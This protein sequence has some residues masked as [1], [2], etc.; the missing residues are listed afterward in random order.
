MVD[1]KTSLKD[2]ATYLGM[3]QT[4]VSRGLSGYPEVAEAT[5]AKIRDAASELNYA[6]SSSAK[7]LS[8]GKALTIGHIIPLSEHMTLN[9]FYADFIAGAGETYAQSG[10]DM[11]ISMVGSDQELQAYREL[12]NSQKVDGFVLSE[13]VS[14]DPRI[15]LLQKLNVPF[16]LHGRS[17]D[18][19]NVHG[20][21]NWL[22]VNNQQGFELATRYLLELGHRDIG[23][24]NGLETF[25]FAHRRRLGFEA[26]MTAF[27]AP[28]HDNWLFNID[29]TEYNGFEVARKL[30]DQPHYP[31]A[32]I[33][34]SVL[35]AMGLQ[36][37]MSLN[38]QVLGRD[39]S[40]ICW[41]D[42]LSAFDAKTDPPQFTAMR[43]SIFEAGALV[44]EML[45]SQ[46]NDPSQHVRSHVLEAELVV[47]QSTD[48]GPHY[49]AMV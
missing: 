31:T 13:P 22:D 3:S 43:S 46:I 28:I 20:N 25:D 14:N 38:G 6:P 32:I 1:K 44:A 49:Q 36:R 10:Y 48:I 37:A 16:V 24:I 39:I 15:T 17:F 5:K 8:I 7:K 23:L 18:K 26:A 33:C 47:G 29:M 40:L 42:C 45:L 27:N 34:S 41:D 12:T 11:L 19:N 9:P 4:T 21:Y 2:L 35:L 30:L